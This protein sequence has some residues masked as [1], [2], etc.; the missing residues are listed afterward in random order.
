MTLLCGGSGLTALEMRSISHT[1]GQIRKLLIPRSFCLGFTVA[2][3]DCS[4]DSKTDT[5]TPIEMCR[6]F[7]TFVVTEIVKLISASFAILKWTKEQTSQY[8]NK[9]FLSCCD[10]FASVLCVVPVPLYVG[11]V[12]RDC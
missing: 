1:N 10:S 11:H 6:G 8:K 5:N 12:Q 2:S 4:R 7:D 3:R 9:N